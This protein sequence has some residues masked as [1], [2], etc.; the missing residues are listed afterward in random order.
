[1]LY[2]L[3]K[4]SDYWWKR[5]SEENVKPENERKE[6]VR[7]ILDRE[8]DDQYLVRYYIFNTRFLDNTIFWWA[9]MN[10]VIHNTLKSD[11]DGYHDHPYWWVS[12]I[13]HGGY[14]ED[15]P[16]GKYWRYPGHLRFRKAKSFHRLILDPEAKDVWSM[17][18]MGP[19]VHEWGF[20]DKN[21]CWVKWN[22]YLDSKKSSF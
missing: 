8:S 4:M 21:N 19:H 2:L 16:G 18:L 7:V 10:L 15:T 5:Q 11:N 17:F 14:H 22:E 13:L 20:L 3:N 6:W 1:M 12:L 9:S